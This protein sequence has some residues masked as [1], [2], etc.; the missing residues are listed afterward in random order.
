LPLERHLLIA[1][2]EP[3]PAGRRVCSVL[4]R[5]ELSGTLWTGEGQAAV[6][7]YIVAMSTDRTMWR[8]RSRRV[9]SVRPATDGRFVF[10]D[11]P[12]G[13]YLLIA[14]TDLDPIDLGDPSFL[15][16]LAPGGVRV[17]IAEGQKNVQ[18]LRI[19]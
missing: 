19:R 10:A 5:T 2:L 17:T 4:A 18:D 7:Y 9:L 3:T 12:A 8:P 1:V 13:E 15:D 11:P 6:D 14:L 16:Q